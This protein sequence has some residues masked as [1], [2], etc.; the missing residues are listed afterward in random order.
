[1]DRALKGER[2]GAEPVM[3]EMQDMGSG[4]MDI[5]DEEEIEE[6]HKS[7]KEVVQD[8][9][10]KPKLQC[11]MVDPSFSMV[12]VQSE[13]SGIVWETA[14]S[15]CSTPWA[16]EGSSPSEQ[17]SLEGSGTQGNIV[18]IMDE[19]RIK[20]KKTS[21]RGKL[22]DRFKK[23]N[24][25]LPKSRI[26]EERPAM[27]EVSLPN[28]RSEN[29]EDAQSAASKD[30]DLFSLISEGFEI[31]NIVVPSKLATVDEEDSGVLAENLAYLDDTPKIKSKHKH[32]P[33]ATNSCPGN[34]ETDI[35]E[36]KQ[37]ESLK[38]SS[39]IS[40]DKQPKK[41]E[42]HM[43]YLEK[44]T[45]LD[46]QT[47]SDSTTLTEKPV[48][49][50]TVQP[51]KPQVTQKEPEADEAVDEDSFV[52]IS[53]VEIAGE[54]L[55]EVFYGNK[56][57]AEP[58][59][60]HE[61][62][63]RN[64]RT[65]REISKTLKE[66]GSVLFG[67]QECILTPVYLPTGPPKI[68]DP[69]LLEEPRAM[70]FHYSDLYEDALG[71]RKKEDDFSDAESVV[72]ERS[73]KRRYSD[74]DDGDGYLEKFILKDET[75]VVANVPEAKEQEDG[76]QF[77][78]SQSKFELTGCLER[79]QEENEVTAEQP[80]VQDKNES[81]VQGESTGCCSEG[82][83][84]PG[85]QPEVEKIIRRKVTSDDLVANHSR[86]DEKQCDVT[87]I[88]N[89]SIATKSDPDDTRP[90]EVVQVLEPESKTTN[91][92]EHS[93]QEQISQN[94]HIQ[95]PGGLAHEDVIKA[96]DDFEILP[97]TKS[98]EEIQAD[99]PHA[100]ENMSVSETSADKRHKAADGIADIW[101]SSIIAKNDKGKTNKSKTQDKI[102]EPNITQRIDKDIVKRESPEIFS[103][104][105]ISIKGP[106]LDET[107]P[108]KTEEPL[109]A[110]VKPSGETETSTTDATK[111]EHSASKALEIDSH[112]HE[113][114]EILAVVEDKVSEGLIPKKEEQKQVLDRIGAAQ[115]VE[116]LVGTAEVLTELEMKP[117]SEITSV[118]RASEKSHS[119][120]TDT[121]NTEL[122]T[123]PENTSEEKIY[124]ELQ[125]EFSAKN[126]K[127]KADAG[128]DRPKNEAPELK[129]T[130][131]K[132]KGHIDI[133]EIEPGVAEKHG[134][135][136]EIK[137]DVTEEA[138]QKADTTKEPVQ[139]EIPAEKRVTTEIK[140]MIDS[141]QECS[142]LLANDMKAR[143]SIE[144]MKVTE[145]VQDLSKVRLSPVVPTKEVQVEE[146]SEINDLAILRESSLG[147]TDIENK[148]LP[149]TSVET[150]EEGKKTQLNDAQI[151]DITDLPEPIS[152]PPPVE[153]DDTSAMR[154][155]PLEIKGSVKV[156]ED[157]QRGGNLS[158]NK[159]VFSQLRSFTPQE[160]L[161]ALS[162]D[163]DLLQE[164]AEE[165]DF[166]MVTEQEARQ[167]EQ[168]L[169]EDGHREQVGLSDQTLETDFEFV[170][171]L[172]SAQMTEY[173]QEELEIQPMDA[174]CL[175][176]HCPVLLSEAEHQN[177]ETASLDE[178]F[179]SIKNQLSELI[180]VLQG[181]SENI[182]DFVSELELA[183]NTV[184]EN[185]NDCEKIIKEHN[186]EVVKLLM[187]QY[188]EMSQAME[189]E[190]KAKLEQLYDQIV[191]FQE[192][193]DK[194]KE[195]MEMTAKEEEE[196]DQLKFLSSSKDIN[197][198]L[199]TALESTMSLELGPRGLLVFE[200][201]A[202]GKSGNGKKNRQ[203]IPVP[204]KPHLQPQQA[205]SAT[206]TSVTV[207]WKVNEDDIID[208]FQVYCMEEPQGAISE[209]YRVTVKE[210][211]C[212]LEDLEPDKCYK[213]W[214]MAVNYT[215]C[216]MPSERLPF[217]TAPSVPVIQTEQ[218]TVLWDTATLRWSAVQ[219]SAV[220]SFTLEYCR[221]YACEREG[222]RSISGIKGY[223]QRVL[224]QPNENYLF[225]IKSV[226]AGGASEQ[227]E[228]ALI[229]TRGT[230]LHFLSETAN[231]V[232]KVSEDRNSVEYPHD[233]YNKMSSIIE[234][235]A[236]MA[237]LLPSLGHYY[238]ETE[239]SKCKA[240]R[241][242]IAYPNV[243]Q[244]S[245][246]GEN[247][248]SWCLL[249]VPTS[250]SCR[251]ELLHDRVESDIFL[252]DIPAR[253]GT[254]LDYSQGRLFFFNAQNG[255]LLGTFRHTFTQPCHPVFVLEQPG[256]LELKMTMEVPEFVKHC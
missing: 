40:A 241:I 39:Q 206:S 27:I 223:E 181:R 98:S 249:C 184:E 226:N 188:N 112:I 62:K 95:V 156:Y 185:F 214:V 108:P 71:D 229:S 46:E 254:L 183:Y 47:P 97:E 160:D 1:M 31:L 159:D 211:Y 53:D 13:D 196:T 161:S 244:T 48:P 228:A 139:N 164:I 253:I 231:S 114:G 65:A 5:D 239:V 212:N 147:R 26:G 242:G 115:E 32:E 251:F 149:L 218:C 216:S 93:G 224:L 30:Q 192:N 232:L 129:Q 22:G 119:C 148:M 133:P 91:K 202:K 236:V 208:C 59:V 171:G 193:I 150:S 146:H 2:E 168:A 88:I 230:R 175:V 246:L 87:V 136:E 194:A 225:Y 60:P 81:E 207:Y 49:G 200:D 197:M 76:G 117:E 102:I 6:L 105:I 172:D 58:V 186:E 213:V 234:C 125:N 8:P 23:S 131:E 68:I 25:R 238:W 67:S 255:Q 220:D 61:Y 127:A 141:S 173:E 89:D 203:A 110:E 29:N 84:A 217:R 137:V 99:A 35:E 174:F 101:E 16:S 54:R 19:D 55:D 243:S 248:A 126:K 187:D 227:S 176:C 130:L 11:L 106:L 122:Q 21:S 177:H 7:L 140:E 28:I 128:A 191:S 199:N 111:T 178:A 103:R 155:S 198:R 118:Q 33:V 90:H 189:E 165:L 73:F 154:V 167:S 44:F 252:V 70:S 37:N 4:I 247:S 86:T 240:Y 10:V 38:Q 124:P 78:W 201:Y 221:Q 215:G 96:K 14:S 116:A 123:K 152:P 34:T 209:E 52:I 42:T 69:V 120:E 57:N 256:N 132:Q 20:R 56:F 75:P 83:C 204:Q 17:Y 74:S 195:T 205:N 107:E 43:D 142:L 15:R 190:K 64:G 45:L 9:S 233:V 180:S 82:H 3:E 138:N 50:V 158:R 143:E 104:G 219:P 210:S 80:C 79:A 66:S 235:P 144:Q 153:E 162:C 151:E 121:A 170:E 166:E 163:Q 250:I 41:D 12:T 85:I 109:K 72:S 182:E 134:K 245:T 92:E 18:I 94:A 169:A 237:E 145:D 135:V 222:L 77:A 100:V 113:N 36:I 157:I 179:D 24:T 51:D 63:E